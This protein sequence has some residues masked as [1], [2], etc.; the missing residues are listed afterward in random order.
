MIIFEEAPKAGRGKD[1]PAAGKP[2]DHD[3]LESHKVFKV[4]REASTLTVVPQ[5]DSAR[6]H[7]ADVQTEADTIVLLIEQTAPAN[8][9]IDFGQSGYFGSV[10]LG[11]IVSM[12]RKATETGGKAALCNAAPRTHEILKT[13][14]LLDRWPY[15][16]DREQALQS[17]SS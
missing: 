8:V 15:F 11:L 3:K 17:F 6:F 1:G 13:M 16:A 14:R 10:T 7:Y 5:G 9:V 4:E 2:V 12:S